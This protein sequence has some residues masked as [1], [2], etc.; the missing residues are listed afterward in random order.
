MDG[1]V[2]MDGHKIVKEKKK[3]YLYFGMHRYW[4]SLDDKMR[5][6]FLEID[7]FSEISFDGIW[8]FNWS[9]FFN[10]C[11]RILRIRFGLGPIK[12]QNNLK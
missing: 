2:Y 1:G 5:F 11:T 10:D 4:D 6:I 12:K 8:I 7:H 9:V 3:K